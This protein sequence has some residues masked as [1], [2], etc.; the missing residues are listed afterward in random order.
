[1]S[2]YLILFLFLAFFSTL[3]IGSLQTGKVAEKGNL[4]L[5]PPINSSHES[6]CDIYSKIGANLKSFCI[7]F[8][9]WHESGYATEKGYLKALGC[10]LEN[11]MPFQRDRA[12]QIIKEAE[13]AVHNLHAAIRSKKMELAELSFD[14]N[15]SPFTLPRLG[16][17]LQDL[18]SSLKNKLEALSNRLFFEAGV[19]VGPIEED[20]FWLIPF[21]FGSSQKI[22]YSPLS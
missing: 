4:T 10:C 12:R 21:S 5:I 17:E 3:S 6:L 14:R 7:K 16:M 20:G 18:R 15:T 19:K 8:V 9:D 22:S 2:R 13:P 11:L 1:M